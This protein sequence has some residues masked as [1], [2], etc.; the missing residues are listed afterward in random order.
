MQKCRLP[1]SVRLR[2]YSYVWCSHR[3]ANCRLEKWEPSVDVSAAARRSILVGGGAPRS[4]KFGGG[5]SCDG[6]AAAA[7]FFN[8]AYL[9]Q[10]FFSKEIMLLWQHV[11]Q[12][13][14]IRPQ[15]TIRKNYKN[16]PSVTKGCKTKQA[17]VQSSSSSTNNSTVTE[18]TL[19]AYNSLICYKLSDDGGVWVDFASWWLYKKEKSLVVLWLQTY[20]AMSC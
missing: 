17:Y 20:I 5:D 15:N 7:K 2:F 11:E 13:F 10:K 16:R 1:L 3:C 19:S 9:F 18:L 14:L 8:F 6:G 12:L 4:K